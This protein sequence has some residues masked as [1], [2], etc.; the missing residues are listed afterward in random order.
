MQSVRIQTTQNVGITYELA[1]LG[2]RIVAQL[3]DGVVMFAYIIIMSVLINLAKINVTWIQVC[4]YLPVLFY[5]LLF[6]VFMNGQSIGKKQMNIK[7]VRLDGGP[8]TLGGYLLRWILRLLEVNVFSGAPAIISIALT[9]H[10]QRLGDLAA[11]TTVIKTNQYVPSRS[12]EIM[13]SIE[14]DYEP[15][16]PEVTRLSPADIRLIEDS[17]KAYKN[18]SNSKPV[19]TITSKVKEHLSLESDMLPIKLL[20]TLLK[21]Y[22]HLTS[23]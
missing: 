1:G 10:G 11:G 14:E 21:D 15:V 5:H 6:E 18:H 12:Q 23:R 22:N 16:F 20:Q 8:P 7:V 13:R 19:L 4:L 3:V 17:L 9:K 2:Q